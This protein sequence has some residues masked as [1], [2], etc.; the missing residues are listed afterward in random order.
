MYPCRQKSMV[1]I[2]SVI[3]DYWTIRILESMFSGVD[4]FD[5]F[6]CD[7]KIARNILAH[8]LK[9][10]S[11][12]GLIVR[13]SCAAD[14]RSA[15]YRLTELGRKAWPIIHAIQILAEDTGQ[16]TTLANEASDIELE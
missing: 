10:M 15:A 7:L 16:Q 6:V 9:K 13:S 8:R 14:G 5:H 3:S 2:R 4:R 11:A 1:D 12:I